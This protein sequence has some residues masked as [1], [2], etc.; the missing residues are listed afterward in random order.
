MI[1]PWPIFVDGGVLC[2]DSDSQ[3]PG[4]KTADVQVN[5]EHYQQQV[6]VKTEQNLHTLEDTTL[7]DILEAYCHIAQEG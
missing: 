7:S 3:I 6:L 1:K 4:L 2:K 5:G